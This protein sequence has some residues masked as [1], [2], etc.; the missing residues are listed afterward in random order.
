MKDLMIGTN[1]AV[2]VLETGG[3]D[4][5]CSSRNEPNKGAMDL[6]KKES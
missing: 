2:E 1:L 5:E 3:F 6:L 4:E